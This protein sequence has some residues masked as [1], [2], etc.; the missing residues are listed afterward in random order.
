MIHVSMVYWQNDRWIDIQ[1]DLP[2]DS[3]SANADGLSEEG[4]C[5]IEQN[6]KFFCRF[7]KPM[8]C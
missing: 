7:E 4:F 5:W 2:V 8:E 6:P 3:A 1:L